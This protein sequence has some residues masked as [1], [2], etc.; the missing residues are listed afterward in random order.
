MVL[1]LKRGS[2]WVHK[3]SFLESGQNP[4][5]KFQ[6]NECKLIWQMKDKLVKELQKTG[7]F[8]LPEKEKQFQKLAN[9]SNSEFTTAFSK[10]IKTYIGEK[11]TDKRNKAWGWEIKVND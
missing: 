11:K 3:D 8:F 7:V 2:T 6:A 5:V 10:V 1:F 9:T 4:Q